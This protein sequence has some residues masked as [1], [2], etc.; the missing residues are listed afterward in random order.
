M[1]NKGLLPPRFRLP[2]LGDTV[3]FTEGLKFNIELLLFRG[4]RA[5][6]ASRFH[7]KVSILNFHLVLFFEG[8]E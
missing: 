3:F 2:F 1:V 8:W 5:I 7:L 6:F 4:P